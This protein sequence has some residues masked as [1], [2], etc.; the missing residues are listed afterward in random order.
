MV[1]ESIAASQVALLASTG[2]VVIGVFHT[3]SAGK[4]GHFVPGSVVP[5]PFDCAPTLGAPTPARLVDTT[6]KTKTSDRFDELAIMDGR[7]RE[8]VCGAENRA[9]T[10]D[11]IDVVVC[12]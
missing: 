7:P 1:A 5:A 10:S 8:R 3:L 12:P 6:R 11:S 9:E 4:T 2:R